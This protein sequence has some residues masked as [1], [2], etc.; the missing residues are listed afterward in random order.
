VNLFAYGTLLDKRI[1]FK[2]LG[3]SLRTPV[4]ATLHGY[5][6]YETTLGYPVVLP[7]SGATTE[8]F[9]FYSLSDADWKR[10]DEYESVHTAPPAYFRRLVTLQGAHGSITAFVYVGNLNFFRTRLKL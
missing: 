10:L 6:R 1:M 7:E 2:V 5:R 8:G 9:V 3:R 4:A